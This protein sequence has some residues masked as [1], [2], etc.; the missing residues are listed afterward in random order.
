MTTTVDKPTTLYNAFMDVFIAL[1]CE[2]EGTAS[3][4]LEKVALHDPQVLPAD[5]A[6]MSKALSEMEPR[7]R[8]LG[9]M[10]TRHWK[11]KRKVITIGFDETNPKVIAV[12]QKVK[13]MCNGRNLDVCEG[14]NYRCLCQ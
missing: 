13:A 1:D 9:V 3:E 5:G 4:L 11:N 8:A 7:L 14:N 10:V 6:R 2:F 12:S